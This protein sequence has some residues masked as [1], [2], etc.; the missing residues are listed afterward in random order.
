MLAPTLRKACIKLAQEEKPANTK[1]GELPC[2]SAKR[3]KRIY[4]RS[5]ASKMER[6]TN[7]QPN[8]EKRA[9]GKNDEKFKPETELPYN[10]TGLHKGK[11]H[12]GVYDAPGESRL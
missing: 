7:I 12:R 3:A 11:T 10:A 8:Q 5:N 9:D 4:L 1:Q 6:Q 2:R